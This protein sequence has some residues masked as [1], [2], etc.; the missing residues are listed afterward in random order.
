MVAKAQN[1]FFQA[2]VGLEAEWG[3]LG[4]YAFCI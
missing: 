1:L 3:T 2:A 4:Y